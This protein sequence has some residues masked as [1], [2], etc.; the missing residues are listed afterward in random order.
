MRNHTEEKRLWEDVREGSL[1]LKRGA[2]GQV[3]KMLQERLGATGYD[4]RYLDKA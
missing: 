4:V 3:V 1:V 2:E